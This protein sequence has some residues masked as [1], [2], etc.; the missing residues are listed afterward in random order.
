VKGIQVVA[1]DFIAPNQ[2]G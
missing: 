2:D 1:V